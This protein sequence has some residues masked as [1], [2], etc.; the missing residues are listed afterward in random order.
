MALSFKSLLKISIT[1]FCLILIFI[2]FG[3]GYI[4]SNYKSEACVQRPLSYG[5]EKLNDMNNAD[6]TCSCIS[7][8]TDLKPFSFN[9]N[10]LISG[11]TTGQ[12]IINVSQNSN[13]NK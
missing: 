5:L 8:S 10:G 6:F 3:F 9:E 13:W 4:Y 11:L 1:L 12:L 2:G 7:T